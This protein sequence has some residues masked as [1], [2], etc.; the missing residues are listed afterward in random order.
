MQSGQSDILY[1][2]QDSAEQI[3]GLPKAHFV[4]NFPCLENL[5]IVKMLGVKEVGTLS[6]HFTIWYLLLFKNMKVDM[7]KP[8]M[9]WQP[10]TQHYGAR[11][12]CRGFHV[13]QWTENEWTKM[14][15]YC[16][17]T[18]VH[19]LGCH[20]YTEFP[21][22]GIRHISKIDYYN[23]F[24]A[25]KSTTGTIKDLSA[26]IDAALVA[27][28]ATA[29]TS[30]EDEEDQPTGSGLPTE[31][32]NPLA[33]T[34]PTD[35]GSDAAAAAAVVPSI[36]NVTGAGTVKQSKPQVQIWVPN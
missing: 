5:E 13:V 32:V 31:F 15:S 3:F 36:S 23:V 6:P 7:Q 24:H 22:N 17:H 19:F 34:T 29:L 28:D 12:H 18:G 33:T 26:E 16:S 9:N 27:M 25:Y 21:G 30:E 20:H 2:L 14:A 35:E 11:Y 1:K 8:F 4:P 10:L